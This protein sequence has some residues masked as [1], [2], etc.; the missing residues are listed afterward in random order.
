MSWKELYTWKGSKQKRPVEKQA[1]AGADE[2]PDEGSSGEAGVTIGPL[3]RS[4]LLAWLEATVTVAGQLF[5]SAGDLLQDGD[6][7]AVA[8]K[9]RALADRVERHTGEGR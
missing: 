5:D 9:L 3:D 2:P 7:Q 1:G 4:A 6:R 8:A